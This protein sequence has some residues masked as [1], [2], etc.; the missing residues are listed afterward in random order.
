MK[1]DLRLRLNGAWDVGGRTTG[2]S[3]QKR[4]RMHSGMLIAL[5]RPMSRGG[6]RNPDSDPVPLCTLED[7]K[8]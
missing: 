6:S 1:L 8:V 3:N 4:E 2:K 7:K 5:S